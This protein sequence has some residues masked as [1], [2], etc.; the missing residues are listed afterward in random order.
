MNVPADYSIREAVHAT[1]TFADLSNVA[2]E[3][4]RLQCSLVGSACPPLETAIAV[5]DLVAEGLLRRRDDMIHLAGRDEVLANY[6][7]CAERAADAWPTAEQ[8]AQRIGQIPFVRMVAVT[9]GL[10]VD[11]LG[12]DGGIDIL[13]VTRPRRLWTTR[14]LINIIARAAVRRGVNV[15]PVFITT[16]RAPEIQQNSMSI[17]WE[18]AHMSVVVGEEISRTMR[19]SNDWI[20]DWMPNATLDGNR[21]HLATQPPTGAQKWIEWLLLLPPFRLFENWTRKRQIA[22]LRKAS[23][24]ATAREPDIGE[25]FSTEVCDLHFGVRAALTEQ[26]WT[27]RLNHR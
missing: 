24:G 6:D 18:L 8:W 19:R 20:Y 26:A 14:L 12:V 27:E 23:R 15:H 22:S 3:L 13:I 1:V 9:G 2:I 17:A 21:D 25:R 16:T 11:A 5:D 7:E 4:G 10:A